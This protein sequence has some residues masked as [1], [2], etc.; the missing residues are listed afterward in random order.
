MVAGK[1]I[2]ASEALKYSNIFSKKSL[3]LIACS[4]LFIYCLVIG[5]SRLII[6]LAI[7]SSLKTPVK[8]VVM[9]SIGSSCLFSRVRLK[10]SVESSLLVRVVW[11]WATGYLVLHN[12]GLL[13]H[14]Q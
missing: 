1:I 3:F 13:C 5:V 7:H 4:P 8:T 10:A 12:Q 9:L 2:T 11:S 14:G 6:N